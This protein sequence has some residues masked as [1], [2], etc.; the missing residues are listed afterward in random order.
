MDGDWIVRP[1]EFLC[2]FTYSESQ[3]A[4][5][6][7][8]GP[9]QVIEQEFK[10]TAEQEVYTAP[11]FQLKPVLP[12]LY[13]VVGKF[14][15]QEGPESIPALVEVLPELTLLLDAEPREI[16]AGA[17]VSIR[18]ALINETVRPVT[19]D[20]LSTCTFALR[21]ERDTSLVTELSDCERA[22][23]R[24]TLAAD[25]VIE[26]TVRWQPSEPGIYAIRAQLGVPTLR[27]EIVA[28]TF[29]RVR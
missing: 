17:D 6:F 19:L 15:V 8:L 14:N 28:H 7:E 24:I 22:D 5:T 16:S 3:G 18:T 12:G 27:P 11:G 10:W 23:R 13:K 29:L 9:G 25:E 2:L 21:A 26:E 1:D 4:R 20:L